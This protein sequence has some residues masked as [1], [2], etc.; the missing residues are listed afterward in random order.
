VIG[1]IL[2]GLQNDG[3]AGLLAVKRCGGVAV[4]QE[5]VD[6]L[7]P[8]MPLSALEYV[9]A[10]YCLPVS[11]MGPVLYRLAQEEP[12]AAPPVPQDILIEVDIAEHPVSNSNNR[13]AELGTLASLTCPDCGGPLWEIEQDQLRRYRC[14]V[15]HGFTAES[16]LAGQSEV[17][18]N[19]LWTAVRTMEER[20]RLLQNM[21][22]MGQERNHSR[23]AKLYEQQA[24]ELQGHAQ[25]LRKL[26]LENL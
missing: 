12:P 19:A 6:A 11:R 25:H 24:A 20:A 2:T 1:V 21:A 5:P 15:G 3:S 23:V 13:S 14:R 26:L 22:R 18:E 4:V 10:D 17:T 8:D 16:L 7:Y 9:E